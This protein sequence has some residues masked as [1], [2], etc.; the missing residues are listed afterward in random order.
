MA[1]AP[2][3]AAGNIGVKTHYPISRR[4]AWVAFAMTFALMLSDYLSRQVINA[5]FPFLKT[6]WALTD[7]QLGSL[8]SIVALTI[9]LTS[10]PISIVA[11]RFGRVKSAAAMALVWALATIAC[12]L[13]ES[14]TGLLI[15]RALVG[16]GEAAYGS[17]G[18]AILM[19][20]FPAHLHST[21]MSSFLSAAMIGSVLGV[22]LGGVIAQTM[23]W[24][25]AFI[26]MGIFGLVVATLFPVLV[27][28]PPALE[29][30]HEPKVPIRS[31]LVKLLTTPTIIFL[32]LAMG[33]SVF[34]Q[35]TYI[36]WL[37]SYL[38]RYYALDPAKASMGTGL[39]IVCASIGMILGG[40]L[41]DKVSKHNRLNRLKIT[42]IYCMIL[43]FVLMTAM[44][45]EPGTVQFVLIGLGLSMSSSF[46]GPILAVAGDVTPAANHATTFAIISLAA[47]LIGGAPG[48]F[49]A[50]WIADFT[51]LHTALL[52]TP[53]S[54]L[55]GALFLFLATRTY[56]RDRE[57]ARVN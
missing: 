37:P 46:N 9:A 55:V 22:A 19:R 24:K 7:T 12:G 32:A 47:M 39:L 14:F 15:A 44:S 34:V 30:G 28:E 11:D 42:M 3:P 2:L 29:S 18:G 36:A 26:F 33:F 17:A 54:G 56:L 53:L 49:V 48:P 25:M 40:V 50:G 21:V 27:K 23:G 51:S 43:G 57:R 8:V 6:T 5:V 20:A 13:A 35:A 31:V 38:N 45:F 16:L 4:Y 10:V 52:I 41:V 1:L